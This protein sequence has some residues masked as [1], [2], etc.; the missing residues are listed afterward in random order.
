MSPRRTRW[1]A[2]TGS[3]TRLFRF[4]TG[5]NQATLQL[6]MT[7]PVFMSSQ[8]T[9]RTM[10]FVLPA[11]LNATNAPKPA[12]GAVA[13]RELPGGRFAVLRFSGGRSTEQETA[14]LARLKTWLS[15]QGL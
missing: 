12:D 10:A 6:A 1:S 14:T 7:T 9:N 5:A 15:T 4:I 3:F 2:P 13:V 8:D 11:K